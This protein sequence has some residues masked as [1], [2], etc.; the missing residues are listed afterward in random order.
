MTASVFRCESRHR[1]R[2]TGSGERKAGSR[3]CSALFAGDA[4]THRRHGRRRGEG[5][6]ERTS[7]CASNYPVGEMGRV[8]VLDTETKGT[9]AQMVPLEKTLRKPSSEPELVVAEP[10]R[11]ERAEKPPEPK[12]PRRFKIV[13][14][15]TREVLT[16]NAEIRATVDLLKTVRSIV[17]VRVYVWETTSGTWR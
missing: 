4:A 17:D 14:V 13:D 11:R 1:V 15:M 5:P 8:W 12:Q 7:R 2:S 3:G 10:K 9:G 6:P 16:D